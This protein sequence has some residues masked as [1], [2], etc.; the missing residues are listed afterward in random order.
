MN[1]WSMQNM[2]AL[3]QNDNER[4]Q[5]KERFPLESQVDRHIMNNDCENYF[6]LVAGSIGYKPRL[7][8]LQAIASKID[9]NMYASMC[10]PSDPPTL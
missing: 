4:E 9:Y 6:S 7:R 10:M 5:F 8:E 3:M 2:L 1:I